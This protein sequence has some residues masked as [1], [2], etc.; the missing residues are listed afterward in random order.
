MRSRS[1]SASAFAALLAAVSAI[2]PLAGETATTDDGSS[3][4]VTIARCRSFPKMNAVQITFRIEGVRTADELVFA[5]SRGS[6][7]ET[8]T[9]VGTFSPGTTIDR[10]FAAKDALTHSFTPLTCAVESVR[11]VDDDAA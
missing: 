1:H 4:H 7:S 5:I 3:A 2:A 9:D 8:L 10:F 6:V 11:Y